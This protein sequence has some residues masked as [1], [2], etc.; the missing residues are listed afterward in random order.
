M[1]PLLADLSALA[2]YSAGSGYFLIGGMLAAG[3]AIA[4]RSRLRD[5]RDEAIRVRDA[6]LDR[7]DAMREELAESRREADDLSAAVDAA[8]GRV[9]VLRD[10]SHAKTEAWA[11]ES[12]LR[13]TAE[14][15]AQEYK[16]LAAVLKADL[17]AAEADLR[18]ADRIAKLE[19]DR[20]LADK[21]GAEKAL[22]F[23]AERL[24]ERCRV[25]AN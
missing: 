21:A 1:T 15:S 10:E 7:F 11:V 8:E 3:V 4:R 25:K 23:A 9:N 6:A 13:A 19:R 16:S 24:R 17:L 5:E 2:P 22:H 14:A 18:E 20:R 12:E